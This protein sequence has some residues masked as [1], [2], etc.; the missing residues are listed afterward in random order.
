MKLL[1]AFSTDDGENF[2]EDHFGMAS[3]FHVYK[4]SDGKEE[5]VEARKNVQY[6]EDET[7]KHGD[8][9][10]AKAT[11]SAVGDV[12]V[13]IGKKMGANIVRLLKKYVSIVTKTNTI[14][15]AIQLVH[16]NMEKIIEEKNK[17]E[18]RKHI[19]LKP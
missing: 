5:F 3:Y 8:P 13:I 12:D 15:D 10:K 14:A 2:N 1:V 11:S 7:L 9:G 4:F 16:R 19:V 17:G 6:K 18:T